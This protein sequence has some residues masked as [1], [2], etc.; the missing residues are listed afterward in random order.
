MEEIWKTIVGYPN[1]MVSNMGNIKSLNYNH[2]GKEKILKARKDRHKYLYVG[3]YKD[4]RRKMCKVHRL[5][6]QAFIE[7]HNNL[8]QVNHKNEIKT[9]NRSENLE[10]CTPK[11]NANYG[12]RNQRMAESCTNHP[13][14]S[15]RVMCVET[16][17]IYPSAREVQ[18]QTG[19]N[20]SHIADVC[21]GKYKQ[22]YGFHWQYVF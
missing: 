4:G 13:N 6:A 21:N 22:A 11:Q 10:W 12:T 1:Y 16:S 9:D 5:V 3:L 14:K 7:N 15:K 17:K 18:R 19:F 2:T 8:E 20:R